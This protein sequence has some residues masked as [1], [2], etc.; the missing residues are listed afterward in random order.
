[1]AVPNCNEL[2]VTNQNT[3]SAPLTTMYNPAPRITSGGYWTLFV[4][5]S[6]GRSANRVQLPCPPQSVDL[7]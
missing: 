3:C 2:I 7:R 4:K 6:S 5:Q 1:M